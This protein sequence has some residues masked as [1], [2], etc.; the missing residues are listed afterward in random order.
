VSFVEE[1]QRA[2]LFIRAHIG[3]IASAV[4]YLHQNQIHHEDLKPSNILIS[5]HGLYITDFGT[6]TGFSNVTH[7][8]TESGERGTPKYFS[9]EA[10]CYDP[11]G[12]APDIFSL[13]CIVFEIILF[14]NR[15]SLKE[16]KKF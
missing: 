9:P 5:S 2:M 3:C 8:I 4:A 6:A 13:G 10:A 12:R 16:M 1:L 15:Y 11:C 14:C 7:S